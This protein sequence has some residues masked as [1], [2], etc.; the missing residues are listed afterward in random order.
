MKE[1]CFIFFSLFFNFQWWRHQES[2]SGVERNWH[3]QKVILQPHGLYSPWNSP[4][5]NTGVGSLS[6]LQGSSQS[7][8][9]TQVLHIAGRFFTEPPGKPKNSE[10]RSLSLLQWIF[11]T[12]ELNWGFLHCRQSFYQLSYQGS[13]RYWRQEEKWWQR[14][15]W[16]DGVTDSMDM[17]L[18]KLREMTKGREACCAAHS[19][20]TKGWTRLRDWTTTSSKQ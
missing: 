6:F 10:V 4:G 18:N 20:V 2:T 11:L 17:N 1:K 9:Q 7:R 12:Q 15:R 5:Y 14:M 8:D 3:F 19:L 16:L 13:P